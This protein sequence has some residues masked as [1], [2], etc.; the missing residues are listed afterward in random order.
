MKSD[1][2]NVTQRR[3]SIQALFF[4]K[5]KALCLFFDNAI[6]DMTKKMGGRGKKPKM[7]VGR[8]YATTAARE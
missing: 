4:S 8:E 1:F 7:L 3:A 6:Y 5:K 2:A